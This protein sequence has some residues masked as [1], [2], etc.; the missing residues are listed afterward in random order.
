MDEDYIYNLLKDK[1]EDNHQASAKYSKNKNQ[2][3]SEDNYSPVNLVLFI[4][5]FK[6]FNYFY[7]DQI[8]RDK[9]ER[10]ALY[11]SDIYQE[12]KFKIN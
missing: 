8:S 1:D 3:Q 4:K 12:K 9:A 11:I 10:Q 7:S 6:L 2:E 5:V